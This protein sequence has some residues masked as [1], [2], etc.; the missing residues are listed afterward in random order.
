MNKADLT[1]AVIGA[2][3]AV[4]EEMIQVLSERRFP[5]K[6]LVPPASK[7]TAGT[8]IEWR[9]D[10]VVVQE[11]NDESFEGVDVALF[12]AGAEV[13]LQY[14]PIAAAAGAVV[15]DNSRAF[16]MD[17]EV[18]LVVP[19]VNPDALNEKAMIIANPNCSTIQK[20]AALQP[21][22]AV[23][24]LK[25]VVV[26]TY[27]SASGAGREAMDELREQTTSLLGFREVKTKHF[28]RRLAFDTIPQIDRFEDD[29][30]T[31]EE[32]KM[33]FETRKIMAKPELPVCATCVRVPVFVGHAM[34]INA[35]FENEISVESAIAALRE[36]PGIIL[37]DEQAEFP[38]AA[39]AAGRDE[40]FVGRLRHDPSV[41]HGL[42]F[43]VV[44]DNL[45][46]GAATNAVQIAECLQEK[47]H[48]N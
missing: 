25:R 38:T 14:G 16:R 20:V 35:E 42:V 23:A 15:I 46:K 47:G 48:L 6:Q 36:A 28:A 33:I 30:F 39:D 31:R 34:S 8:T 45:R 1:V 5:V 3:G 22:H 41:T 21:L 17:P 11:L 27:Q 18:P 44:A 26:S 9:G 43:W 10:D 40:V 32:H 29:G 13:S 37:K 2:T 12:S 24:G 19:E 4:G 7:R